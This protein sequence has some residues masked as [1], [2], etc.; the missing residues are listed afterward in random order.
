MG[1]RIGPLVK[2]FVCLEP[3]YLSDLCASDVE[4]LAIQKTLQQSSMDDGI[5]GLAPRDANS[6]PPY[7]E[8]M[9]KQG[10]LDH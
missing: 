3:T 9:F 8:A 1:Q 5:F 6:G 7:I 4:F 2:D 10:K